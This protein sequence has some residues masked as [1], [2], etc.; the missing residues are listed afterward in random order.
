M[1]DAMRRGLSAKHL[2]LLL[3]ALCAVLLAVGLCIDV[4]F[5]AARASA[6][7]L[8]TLEVLD[9]SADP[10][11]RACRVFCEGALL[12]TVQRARLFSDSKT[13]VDMPLRQDPETV[14]AAFS[15]LQDPNN[16]Q[17]LRAFIAKHFSDPGHEFE[18]WTPP[19]YQDRPPHVM[20]ITNETLRQWA[21]QLNELWV[22]LSRK[23]AS[24]VAAAPQRHSALVRRFGM[25][26]PGGRFRETY[27]WDTYWIIRGLIVCGM[28][29]TA[30][31]LVENLLDDVRK[32]GFVPNGGRIYYLDRSQPPML[33]EM[34]RAVYDA[35]PNKAWLADVVPVLVREY[36]FWMDP[37]NG[38]LAS[39]QRKSG[40]SWTLNI[41][42]SSAATPRPESYAE[43]LAT[44]ERARQ[45]RHRSSDDVFRGL[46]AAA[47]T[48]WDFSSR[49]LAVDSASS[50]GV[51]ASRSGEVTTDVAETASFLASKA[52]EGGTDRDKASEVS[53]DLATIDASG[54]IP[55]DLNCILYRAE[56]GLATLHRLLSDDVGAA[57]ASAN[58]AARV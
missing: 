32:F 10:V 49:W 6:G 16:P 2:V 18:P 25:V 42:R 36:N 17:V 30:R 20:S 39:V 4:G 53:F 11:H 29:D 12:D 54:V 50:S 8:H 47:E 19:D 23:Q 24:S 28:I 51:A 40:G 7:P 56:L 34:V 14:L 3:L 46:R 38:H 43:D 58:Y 37:K 1:G 35:A 9:A 31:G 45:Q 57:A 21:L 27:Y 44:A 26:V 33:T 48:G 41:Y 13:F 55:V 22:T 5:S 52:G 15:Q